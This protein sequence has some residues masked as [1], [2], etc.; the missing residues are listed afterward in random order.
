APAGATRHDVAVDEDRVVEHA[1]EPAVAVD[2]EHHR[3]DGGPL[4]AREAAAPAEVEAQ[5]PGTPWREA[6]AGHGGWI[7]ARGRADRRPVGERDGR[8]VDARRI[9]SPGAL[10]D[11]LE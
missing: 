11:R 3:L 2:V 8:Q 4:V 1:I 7:A 10:L 6:G 9:R 5:L